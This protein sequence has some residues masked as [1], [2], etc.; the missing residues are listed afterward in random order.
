[1]IQKIRMRCARGF[2]IV[3]V[4]IETVCSQCIGEIILNIHESGAVIVIHEQNVA[5]INALLIDD[6]LKRTVIRP[7]SVDFNGS[8]S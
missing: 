6:N 3:I 5:V 2:H 7:G 4:I 8:A 1:M